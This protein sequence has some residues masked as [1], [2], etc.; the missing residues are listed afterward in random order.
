MEA[1]VSVLM[2]KNQEIARRK[3]NRK[4]EKKPRENDSCRELFFFPKRQ[5]LVCSLVRA[6]T[7]F[8]FPQHTTQPIPWGAR[9]PSGQVH[10]FSGGTLL[11]TDSIWAPQP[12]QVV[13][14][15]VPQVVALHIF[16]VTSEKMD[17]WRCG[18]GGGKR[19]ERK[20][21]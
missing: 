7:A 17:F 14:P 9:L 10:H 15:H 20:T 5:R 12:T 2:W 19:V 1:C 11:R 6:P 8:F 3:E 21:E 16:F 13:F 4:G 18:M